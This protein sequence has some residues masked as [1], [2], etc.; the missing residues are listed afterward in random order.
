MAKGKGIPMTAKKRVTRP[1]QKCR[2]CGCTDEDCSQCIEKTGR[3]CT[4][5]FE[6]ALRSPAVFDAPLC[7]ACARHCRMCGFDLVADSCSWVPELEKNGVG[8][9]LPCLERFMGYPFSLIRGDGAEIIGN[10]EQGVPYQ[11]GDIF[12]LT[13]LRSA[14]PDVAPEPVP[15]EDQEEFVGR[16]CRLTGGPRDGQLF[17]QPGEKLKSRAELGPPMGVYTFK[18]DHSSDGREVWEWKEH[19]R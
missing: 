6:S 13:L 7:S 2:I 10:L 11:E 3:P 9:C 19:A 18:G 17:R 1:G 12:V 15:E 5:V 8:V 14:A 4:W 16:K